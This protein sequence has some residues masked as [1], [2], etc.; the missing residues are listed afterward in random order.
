MDLAD[1]GPLMDLDEATGRFSSRAV[2]GGVLPLSLIRQCLK[3][4]LCALV[5]LRAL[6]IA[7]RDIKV[8]SRIVW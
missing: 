3:D 2:G 7:H 8:S 4:L 6:G 1:A 5:D